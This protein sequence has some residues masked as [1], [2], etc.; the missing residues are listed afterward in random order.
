MASKG[1]L[2]YEGKAKKLY[3]TE[4]QQVLW[5][6]YLDQATAFNGEKKDQ[7]SGKAILNNQISSLIFQVLAERGVPNHLIEQ[8][9]D[10]EQLVRAVQ[11]IPLEVVVRNVA[12]GSISKRLGIDE[13]TPLAFPVVEF[14]YKDDDLGDPLISEDHIRLLD[15]ATPADLE[16]IRSQALT[17]N[18]QLQELFDSCGITLVD[19]K[20]EFG[21]DNNGQILLADEVS[22]DT[23]R[24]WDKETGAHLDK[25]VYRR[26]LGDLID[27]YQVVRARLEDTLA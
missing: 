7:I 21:R 26:D 12:A 8:L 2:L 19:F 27:V 14:Y 22:P 15:I 16:E 17:V 4:D 24:L 3:A 9:S 20:L 11:I 10:T 23:S 5:V 6:E 13:G 18:T 1:Q 25:D